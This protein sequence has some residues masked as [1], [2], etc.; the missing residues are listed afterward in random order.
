MESGWTET[1]LDH[2]TFAQP[3]TVK[4]FLQRVLGEWDP[5]EVRLLFKGIHRRLERGEV[6]AVPSVM[7]ASEVAFVWKPGTARAERPQT[8][9]WLYEKRADGKV[10]W[11]RLGGDEP[12]PA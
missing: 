7:V 3:V 8:D 12:G 4:S 6:V 9:I 10:E 1:Y 2:C 11:E 5:Q